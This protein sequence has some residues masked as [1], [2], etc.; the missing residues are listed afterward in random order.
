MGQMKSDLHRKGNFVLSTS[1]VEQNEQEIIF[2]QRLKINVKKNKKGDRELDLS[3][4]EIRHLHKTTLTKVNKKVKVLRLNSNYLTILPNEVT[5]FASVTELNLCNNNFQFIPVQIFSLNCLQILNLS[6]NRI[7]SVPVTMPNMKVLKKIDF[8]YNEIKRFVLNCNA[9]ENVEILNLDGN[10][11]NEFPSVQHLKELRVLTLFK[12]K[13]NYLPKELDNL[14]N[15]EELDVSDNNVIALN[16]NLLDF[17]RKLKI[18]K[19]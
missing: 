5:S 12:N 16:P 14:K 3:M 15:L 6:C 1:V 8:S 2:N 13:I 19:I 7:W 17:L 11:L 18:F 9:L 10:C 4:K